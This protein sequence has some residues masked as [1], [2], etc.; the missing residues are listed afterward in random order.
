M[1]H[2]R[3]GQRERPE[4]VRRERHVPAQRVLR[5]TH[6][7]ADAR[8]VEQ[9]GDRKMERDDFRR[10]SRHAHRIRQFAHDRNRVLSFLLDGLLHLVE[11][12][13][14][15]ADQDDCAVLG[16]FECS[17]ATNAGGRSGD[18]VRLAI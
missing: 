3:L 2:E 17:A 18:D 7:P 14:V 8:V 5:R 4:V 15:S 13:A 12:S 11:L 16:Q 10:R 9:A 1:R 6:L